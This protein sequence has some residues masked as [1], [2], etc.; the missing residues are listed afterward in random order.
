MTSTEKV[1]EKAGT[2]AII[3]SP[4]VKTGTEGAI[5]PVSGNE[6]LPTIQVM[7]PDEDKTVDPKA[8]NA[9]PPNDGFPDGG[10]RAWLVVVG[11]SL[12]FFYFYFLAVNQG[13][14]ETFGFRACATALLRKCSLFH[15]N[16]SFF[17]NKITSSFGYVNSWGVR[18]VYF[19]SFSTLFNSF[20]RKTDLPRILSADTS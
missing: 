14:S 18:L 13:G 9:P 6:S 1:D 8:G 20:T 11:V 2:L 4:L 7:Q 12:E 17:K 3:S 19:P 15:Q 5:S 16:M 10:L